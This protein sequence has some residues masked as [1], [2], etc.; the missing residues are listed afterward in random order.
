M[1]S[2]L[3]E[4]VVVIVCFSTR[5]HLLIQLCK[6]TS[7]PYPIIPLGK[8]FGE[9][10]G[11]STP[12]ESRW[13]WHGCKCKI[14]LGPRENALLNCLWSLWALFYSSLEAYFSQWSW[15]TKGQDCAYS[16]MDVTRLGSLLYLFHMYTKPVN[17]LFSNP[18][19]YIIIPGWAGDAAGV[20]TH[21]FWVWVRWFYY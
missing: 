21:P 7:I 12:K 9:W 5:G 13:N 3:K 15:G 17:E 11:V 1:L 10:D 4:A 16:R 14:P 8:D 6:T 20:L 19:W 2:A 18:C